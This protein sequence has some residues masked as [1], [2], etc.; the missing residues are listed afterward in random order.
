LEGPG[1]PVDEILPNVIGRLDILKNWTLG[2]IAIT[3]K[4]I[5]ELYEIIPIGTPIEIKP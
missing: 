5:D 2:C 1:E 3:D 4:E